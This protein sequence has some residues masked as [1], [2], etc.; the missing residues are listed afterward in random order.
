[1]SNQKPKKQGSRFFRVVY[2]LLSGII[3]LIFR[4]KVVNPENEPDEGGF[5]VCANHISATDPIMLCYAFRKHQVCFM[6]KKELFKIPLLSGFFRML[7]A[8]PVDRGGNDVGAIKN[9][10]SIVQEGRCLGVFPQGHRYPGVDPRET[11]T[12]NGAALIAAK[13][14]AAVIP[15]YIWHKNK[16]GGPFRRT[17]VII[18][19]KIP[20]EAFEYDNDESGEYT[21]MTDA[22]FHKI[23]VLGESFDR[24]MSEKSR[25]RKKK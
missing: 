10:I 20:F 2:A 7:G 17:Y 19:E 12:K 4:I 18:G 3:G 6:A 15:A 9:A 25:K 22:I 21:R 1:M 5:V 16:K 24:E 13:A 8:F 11:D 14:G 23:C